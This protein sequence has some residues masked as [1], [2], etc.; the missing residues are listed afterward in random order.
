VGGRIAETVAAPLVTNLATTEPVGD[1]VGVFGSGDV[2][3]E[4][5]EIESNAR[6]AGVIDGSDR[7]IIIVGGKV[8][9]GASGLKVVIQNTKSEG[10]Q[11]PEADR[12]VPEKALGV[13]APKLVLPPVL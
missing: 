2:K 4:G 6:A 10:L 3:L 7:A 12:S 9:A 11:I 1:G 13:S 8:A 5:A